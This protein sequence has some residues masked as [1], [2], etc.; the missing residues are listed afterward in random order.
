MAVDADKA[1]SSVPML[2]VA[3]RAYIGRRDVLETF[4][5]GCVKLEEAP[6]ESA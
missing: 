2:D 1:P 3:L 6:C 4:E 5:S